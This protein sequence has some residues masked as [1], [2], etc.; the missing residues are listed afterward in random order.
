MRNDGDRP[1]AAGG[2]TRAE[3]EFNADAETGKITLLDRH[4]QILLA[5]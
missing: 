4:G 3:R 1:G 2:D 5:A